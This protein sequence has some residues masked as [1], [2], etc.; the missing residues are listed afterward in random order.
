MFKK[1]DDLD[2]YE[3][4]LKKQEN[5]FS[6]NELKKPSNIVEACQWMS[7]TKILKEEFGTQ[8]KPLK[9]ALELCPDMPEILTLQKRSQVLKK[10][11]DMYLV[12]V[13]L[14]ICVKL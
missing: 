14:A 11:I 3:R 1:A 4:W 8:E 2:H 5:K 6:Q 12:K 13:S 9:T 10:Q 7:S